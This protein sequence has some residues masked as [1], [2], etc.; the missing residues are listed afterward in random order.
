MSANARKLEAMR[1]PNPAEFCFIGSAVVPPILFIAGAP[2]LAAIAA[3]FLM[4]AGGVCAIA[5]AEAP[6]RRRDR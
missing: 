2:V 6:H 1:D 3:L 5:D 4:L